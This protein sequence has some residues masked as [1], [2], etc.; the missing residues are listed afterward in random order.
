MVVAVMSFLHVHRK[1]PVNVQGHICVASGL[2]NKTSL[3]GHGG[4]QVVRK[5]HALSSGKGNLRS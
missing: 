3:L 4:S 5:A 1:G 2:S